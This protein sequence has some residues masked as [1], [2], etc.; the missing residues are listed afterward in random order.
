MGIRDELQEPKFELSGSDTQELETEET[1]KNQAK[2]M[3]GEL[4][5]KGTL[6][7]IIDKACHDCE[8]LPSD[9]GRG[10]KQGL[11]LFIEI[12]NGKVDDDHAESSFRQS[13]NT[14]L[15]TPDGLTSALE[16]ELVRRFPRQLRWN[17][18]EGVDGPTVKTIANRMAFVTGE[19]LRRFKQ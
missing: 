19:I 13:L 6:Q 8:K 1:W 7:S 11:A 16:E 5:Q 10:G 12:S 2:E 9:F 17:R 18:E 3:I 14:L 15:D 4:E